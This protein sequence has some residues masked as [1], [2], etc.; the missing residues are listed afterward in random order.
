MPQNL[1]G[2]SGQSEKNANYK[3]LYPTEKHHKLIKEFL[4]KLSPGEQDLIWD[5]ILDLGKDPRPD[6]YIDLK[7]PILALS[8]LSPYRIAQGNF[9]IFY[10]IVDERKRVYILAVKRRNEKTYRR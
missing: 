10:D 4:V 9:R 3:V 6:G 1:S 2:K 7:P 5:A 8:F